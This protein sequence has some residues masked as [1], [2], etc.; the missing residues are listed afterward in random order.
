MK[1]HQL[2]T[3]SDMKNKNIIDKQQPYIRHRLVNFLGNFVTYKYF[4]LNKITGMFNI[5]GI[6]LVIR[7]PK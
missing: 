2:I 4:D 7:E 1:K 6:K 5:Y 3:N